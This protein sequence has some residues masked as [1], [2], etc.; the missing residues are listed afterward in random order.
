MRPGDLQVQVFMEKRALL[1]ETQEGHV[2]REGL[3][4]IVRSCRNSGTLA[5]PDYRRTTEKLGF[6]LADSQ[7]LQSMTAPRDVA[8]SW[9]TKWASLRNVIANHLSFCDSSNGLLGD[10]SVQESPRDN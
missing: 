5:A 9:H 3:L 1:A 7:S 4:G 6:L 10:R 2:L 8:H